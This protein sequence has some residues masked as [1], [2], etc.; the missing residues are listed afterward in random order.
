MDNENIANTLNTAEI[1]SKA[2]IGVQE[3][4]VQVVANR[5]GTQ[6]YTQNSAWGRIWSIIHW[7]CGTGDTALAKV[8][9]LTASNLQQL[10]QERQKLCKMVESEGVLG[11]FW[12]NYTVVEI[13]SSIQRHLKVSCEFRPQTPQFE[14]L[15]ATIQW[16]DQYL[17]SSKE[18]IF[19]EKA[20][21]VFEGASSLET[22]ARAAKK[23]EVAQTFDKRWIELGGS[24]ITNLDTLF[25]ELVSVY[26][27]NDEELLKKR[28]SLQDKLGYCL[29]GEGWGWHKAKCPPELLFGPLL[30]IALQLSLQKSHDL[31]DYN[32][33]FDSLTTNAS[34]ERQ[35]AMQKTASKIISLAKYFREANKSERLEN[36]PDL[37]TKKL[38]NKAYL[39]QIGIFNSNATRESDCCKVGGGTRPK[40]ISMPSFSNYDRGYDSHRFIVVEERIP[41]QHRRSYYQYHKAQDG[42]EMLKTFDTYSPTAD[43]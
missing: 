2:K 19:D 39:S 42:T 17:K 10:S 16:A 29:G 26:P 20:F 30:T 6:L 15:I 31:N 11:E 5:K 34:K 21:K 7:I 8:I 12:K 37:I 33:F 38:A 22:I 28:D 41:F 36:I 35:L 40:V 1:L 14:N 9:R 23:V 4:P 43:F 13:H 18:D 32:D 24:T 27:D 3:K 25:R